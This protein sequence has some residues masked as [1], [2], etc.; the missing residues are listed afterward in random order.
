MNEDNS[1]PQA[2]AYSV[3]L[4]GRTLT[5]ETGKYAKQVS[6]SVWVTYGETVV[7]A[8]AQASDN[9]IQADFLP[10][11]VEFEERHYAVGR[12]PGSFMRREGRPG[13]KAI[14]S[15]RLTDRPIRPLFPKG[16]RHE[17]QVLLTVLSAD[18]ENTPDILGPIAA[19][20]ALMLSNIPWDGPIA[21]VRVGL[22]DGRFVLNPVVTEDSQLELV[23]A[24]SKDAIIMVEAG[25]QEVSE[26]QLVR[27]LEFA[28]RAMQ[29]VL[30]LQEQ[31]RAELGKEKFSFEPPAKLGEEELKG[32]YQRAIEKGLSNVLLTAS[33]GERSEAME[34]FSK[35]LVEEL[36]PANADGTVDE[37]RRK[38][39]ASGFDDVV[40]K[41]LR[42][43]VLQENKRADG[44]NPQQVRP[45]W[46]ETNVLPRP[47]GSAVF[48]RG[49]T[50]VLGTVTLGTGR[51]AQLVDDLG[52][53]TEDPFLVHYN[54]PP[55]ST[56]EVKRL[57]GVSRREVGH[58]NLAKRAL[59][60]VL[61]SKDEFPYTIRVVGDVLES[62]GSSSMAT[63]CAGCL[64]LLDAGVP[65][66]KPVAGVAMGL[67]KE[68]E[69][70]VVLTDI[71]G[72]ED[73]LG[74]MDFKVT[75]TRDGVTALQMDIKVKGLAAETMR[76][77]LMQAKEARLHI[78]D[79]MEAAM[80]THRAQM[81]PQVP[82]ILTLK[83][84]PEKIGGI[85]GP[86]GKNIRALEEL[87]VE[88]DIEQDGTIRLY[89]AN[90]AAAEEAKARILGQ[91][92]EAKVGEIYDGK[93]VRITNFGAFIEILPGKDGLLH[94]SQLSQERVERV[95]DVLKLGDRLKVKVNKIDDQGKVDLIRPEL[96]GLI[97]PRKPPVRR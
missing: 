72:L 48:S 41:E 90:G 22:Q 60:P 97:A 31:M 80:P 19:S 18:Q 66:K 94:I 76:A 53:D 39:I 86:G 43:L 7:M 24:G 69:Q 33:K 26:D 14:L 13:E 54:F 15:A 4:G 71:L 29:P 46:I 57:R 27:A 32:L 30:E 92:A 47:H 21:S 64:A 11:T 35:E 28:H 12:I 87:G 91:T 56:G 10:L 23:V 1:I 67:V 38:L 45:I 63:T 61:P 81:K 17:I 88:I 62:N 55:Y 75:G 79:K 78:L 8:T 83:I 65:L 52:L 42:R 3:E 40:K 34:K 70:A 2:Q 9:P 5:I 96:E 73:A 49:E 93:V 74:D 89:S 68:G 16:F 82:R 25:A 77:A 36:V 59:K 50:Q 95:E 6:G 85:I 20:A 84:N 44:R 58:G 37:A 51:D